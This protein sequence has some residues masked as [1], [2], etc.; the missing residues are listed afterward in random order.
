MNMVNGT[1]EDFFFLHLLV[2]VLMTIFVRC[3]YFCMLSQNNTDGML[4]N[5]IV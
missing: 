5:V 4:R 3:M 2:S 1:V